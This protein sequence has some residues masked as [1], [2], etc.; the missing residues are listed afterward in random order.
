MRTFRKSGQVP[1]RDFANRRENELV[2]SFPRATQCKRTQSSQYIGIE[3]VHRFI[4][5]NL[6]DRQMLLDCLRF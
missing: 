1:D 6:R 3:R 5:S 2:K 4:V